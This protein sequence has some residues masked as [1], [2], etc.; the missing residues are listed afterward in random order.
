MKYIFMLLCVII[1]SCYFFPFELIAIPGINSKMAIALIGLIIVIYKS[2]K[3]ETGNVDAG[4]LVLSIWAMIIGLISWASTAYNNTHDYSFVTY[5]ISMWVWLGGAYAMVNFI[6]NCHGYISIDLVASYLIAVCVLQCT[7]ALVFNYNANAEDWFINT[8]AGEAFMGVTDGQRMHGIGCALDVAGF[9]FAAVLT[10]TGVLAFKASHEKSISFWVL[11][12]AFIFIIVIGDMISRSTF[13]GAALTF[14]FWI[15]ISTNK[16][17]LGFLTKITCTIILGA[18]IVSYLYF[19]DSSF[20]SSLRFGFEGFFSLVE[21]GQWQTNSTDILENMV[22]FPDNLKTW[23]IGDG[24]AANPLDVYQSTYDP[25][26][27]GQEFHGFY[28][29]TDIG[30]LRYIFYFGL[31]GL[32]AFIGFFIKVFQICARRFPGYGWFFFMIL[33]IN[34]IGWFKVS[35]DLFMV[36]APFLCIS[37]QEQE[38]AEEMK[39]EHEM[40]SA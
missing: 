20:A 26:Y 2:L 17:D 29:Q 13:I 31:L 28:M 34:F 37:A 15:F 32:F 10:M 8:F 22:V 3:K 21:T 27:R 14:V 7:F 24:Y 4:L 25:Y 30:Y 40:I 9:R 33:A 39:A 36:F 19:T 16:L 5:V 23:I 11:I 38:E 1:S 12:T 35:S 18:I 6:K